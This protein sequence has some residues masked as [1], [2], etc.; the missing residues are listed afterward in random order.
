VSASKPF[1]PISDVLESDPDAFGVGDKVETDWVKQTLRALDV[2]TE[3]SR[4]LRKR[5]LIDAFKR[6]VRSGTYWRID[7][8]IANYQLPTA[9]PC[10]DQ[11]VKP[12]ARIRSVSIPSTMWSGSK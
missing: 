6:N 5:A 7:T 2:A 1:E 3:E 9:M 11:I 4:A 12:L 8:R 10:A